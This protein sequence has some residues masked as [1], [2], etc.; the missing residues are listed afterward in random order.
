MRKVM[1]M[2][3]AARAAIEDLRDAAI[4]EGGGWVDG[5]LSDVGRLNELINKLAAPNALNRLIK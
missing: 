2:V 3:N 1:R 5:L 4:K